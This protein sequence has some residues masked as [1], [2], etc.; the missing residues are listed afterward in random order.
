[1]PVHGSL[2]DIETQQLTT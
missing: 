2:A 1:M